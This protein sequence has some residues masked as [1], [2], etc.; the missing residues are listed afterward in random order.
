MTTKDEIVS[1]R[2]RLQGELSTHEATIQKIKDALGALKTVESL[3]ENDQQTII[4]GTGP[5]SDLGPEDLMLTIVGSQDREWT[6][7]EILNEAKRGGKDIG[8]YK[9]PYAVF[10]TALTRL[11]GK[12]KI[13]IRKGGS[14]KGKNNYYRFGTKPQIEGGSESE[15]PEQE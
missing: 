2:R 10:Y 4:P 13:S 12:D 6:I 3:L 14:G 7:P 11:A 9:V 5:Y 15:E 1:L 8:A